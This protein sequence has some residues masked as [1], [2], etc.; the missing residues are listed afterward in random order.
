MTDTQVESGDL[1]ESVKNIKPYYLACC[2]SQVNQ[3]IQSRVGG[4]IT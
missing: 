2:S 1:P 4:F 3:G